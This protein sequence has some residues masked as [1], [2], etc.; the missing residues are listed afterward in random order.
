MKLL[1]NQIWKDNLESDQEKQHSKYR[2]PVVEKS[3]DFSSETMYAK[4][5]Q[6]ILFGVLKV[7]PCQ[8]R[9]VNLA[10]ISFKNED[11]ME[12]FLDKEKKLEN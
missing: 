3:T 4:R 5:Q 1:R 7:K 12:I 8:G 9:I 11:E 6:N 10:K 2:G